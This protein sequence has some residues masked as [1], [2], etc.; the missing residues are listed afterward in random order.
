M[1]RLIAS[2][3][4]VYAGISSHLLL[5]ETITGAMQRGISRSP[6]LQYSLSQISASESSVNQARSGWLPTISVSA[7]QQALG[8]ESST[9]DKQYA[10]NVQQNLFDFGRTG[11]RVDNAKYTKGSQIWKAIA[12]AETTS[13]KIAEAYINIIKGQQLLENNRLEMAEHKR[14]LGLATD[15]ANGGVDNQGDVRQVDVRI[16]GLEADAENIRAQLEAANNQYQILVGAPAVDLQAPDLEFL[17]KEINKDLQELIRIAPETRALQM[18]QAAAGAQ[19]QYTRKNW[20]PQLSVSLSEGKT[21]IYGEN[22]TQVMLNV[23]SNLFDGGNSYFESENAAKQ[24]ESARWNVQKSMEDAAASVT[25]GIQEALGYKQEAAIYLMRQASSEQV[26][27]LYN[28]QYRVNRRS[29]IDL[30]NAAQEYY[31]TIASQVNSHAS[32][33]ISLIRAIAKLGRVNQAFGITT[34]IEKD[35]EIEQAIAEDSSIASG[36]A[37][38][39]NVPRTLVSA[40]ENGT[41]ATPLPVATLPPVANSPVAIRSTE[42]RMAASLT[43]TGTDK[44]EIFIE[45][46]LAALK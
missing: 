2:A 4:G 25:Q 37:M 28:D 44:A 35:E 33:N 11:N 18:E 17:N 45:D 43:S 10:L 40:P 16:R 41:H 26:M 7:G 13:S 21:S 15:R 31:Q 14:I 1:K 32:Y 19:Y 23:T 5:A 27:S 42:V 34:G 6:S 12:E 3:F 9:G 8:Q 39:D 46:P 38:G 20:L 29:V 30:L 36:S 24:V 22:D